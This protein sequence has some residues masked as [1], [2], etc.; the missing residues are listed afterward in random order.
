MSEIELSHCEHGGGGRPNCDPREHAQHDGA[1]LLGC[2][3]RRQRAT[4]HHDKITNRI[5]YNK[6]SDDPVIQARAEAGRTRHL[7]KEVEKNVDALIVSMTKG[8]IENESTEDS[9]NDN[10]VEGDLNDVEEVRDDIAV[11]A[12]LLEHAKQSFTRL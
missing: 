11:A 1:T 8:L 12:S 9:N 6:V 3:E 5:G 7:Q 10:A 2:H 4:E